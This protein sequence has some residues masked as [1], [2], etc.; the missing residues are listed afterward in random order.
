[1]VRMPDPPGLA[2]LPYGD[3]ANHNGTDAEDDVGDGV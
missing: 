3:Q 2:A 1:M